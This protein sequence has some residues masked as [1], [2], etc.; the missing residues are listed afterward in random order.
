MRLRPPP[1]LGFYFNDYEIMMGIPP[2][3]FLLV[4]IFLMSLSPTLFSKAM[5]RACIIWK[6]GDHTSTNS[7][8]YVSAQTNF[9]SAGTITE[10]ALILFFLR[11]RKRVRRER[12]KF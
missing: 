1:P 6:I 5:L 3:F 7:P 2:F 4:K 11:M 9:A 10:K 8:L 12:S